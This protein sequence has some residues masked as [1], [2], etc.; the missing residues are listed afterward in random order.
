MR[1]AETHVTPG[2]VLLDGGRKTHKRVSLGR[3][4]QEDNRHA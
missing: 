3:S 4:S 1:D 2:G